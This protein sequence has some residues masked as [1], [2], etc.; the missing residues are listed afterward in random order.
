M[1]AVLLDIDGVLTVSWEPL[2][3]AV[4]TV[5]WLRRSNVPFLLLTNTTTPGRRGLADLLGRAGFDV[6]P[7]EIVTAAVA[8]AAYLRA[9]RP[10]ARCFLLGQP[11]LG[12]DFTGIQVVDEQ[13]DVVVVAGA[14]DAFT[15]RNLNKALQMLRSGARLVAMHRNLTWMTAEGLKLDSGAFI[16]GLEEAAGVRATVIGK[17]NADFFLRA[18]A[19]LRM[20][21]DRVAM[22]GD[23]LENDVIAAQRVGLTGVLVRTGKF[24]ADEL[25]K[26][27]TSPDHVSDSVTDLP[28]LIDSGDA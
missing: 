17:P 9:E 1:E 2:P 23:D 7:D 27:S 21:A 26:A 4:E 20:D 11:D 5:A 6:S 10:D 25:R 22:V 15:W 13:A 8:T 14:D 19:A 16:L 24:D 3:G 18:L 12:D 28:R